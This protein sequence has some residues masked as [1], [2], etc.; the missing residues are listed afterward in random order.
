MVS[1]LGSGSS[2]HQQTLPVDSRLLESPLGDIGAYV[3]IQNSH[4]EHSFLGLFYVV[5]G[6]CYDGMAVY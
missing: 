2:Q 5:K 3:G 1:P 6:L 4:D